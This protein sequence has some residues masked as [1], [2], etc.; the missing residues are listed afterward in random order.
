ML[1]G[2]RGSKASVPLTDTD[3]DHVRSAFLRYY[4]RRRGRR[5]RTRIRRT[6]RKPARRQTCLQ[7]VMNRARLVAERG[8]YGGDAHHETYGD[9]A[10]QERVFRHRHIVEEGDRDPRLGLGV[11]GRLL[12]GHAGK[13]ILLDDDCG[14]KKAAEQRIRIR[15]LPGRDEVAVERRRLR[16]VSSV[17]MEC[18]PEHACRRLRD[19]LC[20]VELRSDGP[21]VE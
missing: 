5:R 4:R 7:V 6:S 8:R 17:D 18:A 11:R 12:E 19:W 16:I 14:G 15:S 2:F 13:K 9:E 3:Y 10:K 21:D 1:P 20:D